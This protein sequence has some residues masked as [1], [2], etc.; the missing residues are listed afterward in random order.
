LSIGE[1]VGDLDGVYQF[2]NVLEN[3]EFKL[4]TSIF[5]CKSENDWLQNRIRV[6]YKIKR[7]HILEK[8]YNKTPLEENCFVKFPEEDTEIKMKTLFKRNAKIRKYNAELKTGHEFKSNDRT[9][10]SKYFYLFFASRYLLKISKKGH[11]LRFSL[12][13]SY[14]VEKKI[15]RCLVCFIFPKN[16]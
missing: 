3:G 12:F 6:K 1:S 15:L 7:L 9:R 5:S 14:F 16:F 11:S 10:E 4:Y 8:E 2:R 13:S